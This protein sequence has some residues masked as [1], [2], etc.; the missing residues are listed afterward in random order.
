M[1]EK[2]NVCRILVGNQKEDQ[3]VG[4]HIILKRIL[5]RLG[6]YGQD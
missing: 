6:R 1:E 3:D 5:D 2:R 4:G